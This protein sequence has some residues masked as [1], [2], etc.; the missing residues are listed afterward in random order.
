MANAAQHSIKQIVILGG[1]TA[2]WMTA[3]SLAHYLRHRQCQITLIE[4]CAIGTVGVGEATIPS[5]VNFN[6]GL[7]IDE[8]EFL[9]ATQGSFKLGIQFEDWLEPGSRFFHPFSDYGIDHQTLPFHHYYYALKAHEQALELGDYSLACQLARQGRFAQPRQP[10]QSPLGD[11][12]YAYHFDAGRYALFLREYA[13]QRGVRRIDARMHGVT[14]NAEN[15]FIEALSLDDGQRVQGDLFIDCSGFRALLMQE[16]LKTGFEDWSHWLFADSAVAVQSALPHAEDIVPYTR[17]IAK[18]AGWVWHIPLQHRQGNGYVYSSRFCDPQ[19]AWDTLSQCL[20]H[21]PC[22]EPRHL[23]FKTGRSLKMWEGNCVAIGLSSGFLEPLESTSI[24]LIQT[25]IAHLLQFFPHQGIDPVRVKEV[26]RRHRHEM[27]S[28]RDFILLHYILN[29]RQHNDMWHAYR[30]LS[31]PDT[32]EHKIELFKSCGHI[33]QYPPETF[34]TSSWLT[35]FEGFGI[36][37]RDIDD[38]ASQ[39]PASVLSEQ[40]AGIRQ[41]LRHVAAQADSHA[42]VIAKHCAAPR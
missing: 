39:M 22:S 4:S 14:R 41:Q 10:P 38:R 15:G 12:G 20:T 21:E 1:G 2:G 8:L 32:L 28:I 40:L 24:S 33:V 6:H 37:P 13:E 42:S 26:N 23:S 36:R 17:S 7:G 31:L 16:T 11:Y 34:E 5:I 29:Q 19:R 25:G 3:A 18:D 30:N 9:R 35:M 27:E